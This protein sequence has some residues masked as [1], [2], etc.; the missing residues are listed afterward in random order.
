MKNLIVSL[1][2]IAVLGL[3]GTTA[4]AFTLD[5]SKFYQVTASST[6]SGTVAVRAACNSGDVVV[7][8]ICYSTGGYDGYLSLSGRNNDGWKCVWI[9]G[10]SA[11][12]SSQVTCAHP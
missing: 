4:S 1:L 7:T 2:V 12:Y 11:T 10:A 6:S 8:G 3:I 5:S 9:A